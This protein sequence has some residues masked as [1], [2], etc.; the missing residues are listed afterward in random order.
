[1]AVIAIKAIV[2]VIAVVAIVADIAI[3]TIVAN[4][5][6]HNVAPDKSSIKWEYC[7]DSG[8]KY[9]IDALKGIKRLVFDY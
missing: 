2:T 3:I 1:M 9:C 4:V 8:K 5:A 7:I 6:I